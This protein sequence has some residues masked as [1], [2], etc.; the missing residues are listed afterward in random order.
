MILSLED[1]ISYYNKHDK[2]IDQFSKSNNSFNDRQ[3]L[4]KYNKYVKKIDCKKKKDLEKNNKPSYW[5]DW[6][7]CRDKV[8][9]RDNYSCRLWGILSYE[10]KKIFKES[11]SYLTN[12]L[13]PAH[14]ISRGESKNL[15]CEVKNIVLLDRAFHSRLDF[16]KC[17][18]SGKSISKIEREKW[19]KRI[20]GD[21]L[22]KWLKE[23]K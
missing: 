7:V 6:V 13:D 12:T 11:N 20:I 9:E 15:I 4:S 16:C 10:E 18:L 19:L 21:D 14:I 17:P 1:Y 22:F 3:L 5:D 23:N 8:Y 2:C